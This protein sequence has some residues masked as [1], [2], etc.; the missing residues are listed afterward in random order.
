MKRYFIL[1]L[2]LFIVGIGV[3]RAEESNFDFAWKNDNVSIKSIDGFIKVN[4]G[5]LAG[6]YVNAQDSY[7]VKFDEKG[8]EVAHINLNGD[9]VVGLYERGSY[10]YALEED[11]WQLMIYKLNKTNLMVASK[12]TTPL[13]RNGANYVVEF[14]GNNAYITTIADDKFGGFYNVNTTDDALL[15]KVNLDSWNYEMVPLVE[16]SNII[17]YSQ[18]NSLYSKEYQLFI[19]EINR[20]RVPVD[21]QTNGSFNVVVGRNSANITS[22]GYVAVYDKD[23]NLLKEYKTAASSMYY[24][25]V[26]IIGNSILAVGPNHNTIDVFDFDAKLIETIEI[27]DQYEGN[28]VFN[29]MGL[30]KSAGGFAAAYLV[31]DLKSDGCAENCKQGIIKYDYLYNVL[32]KTDGNGEV[33][34]V[35]S[36]ESGN[37]EVTFN[38]K[39]NE[40]YV[41]GSV[42][43][44]DKDGKV[45]TLEKNTFTMP[46]DDVVIEA[47]FEL[48]NPETYVGYGIF[49]VLIIAILSFIAIIINV[50]KARELL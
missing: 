5:Y 35:N 23:N 38:I 36:K 41:L 34:A 48:K 1:F 12:M 30:V 37:S 11:Y 27:K 15:V 4:G 43:V 7:V 49:G 50:K 44:T 13:E 45:I 6:G 47:K 2:I 31:C 24:T 46:Y 21:V 10:Y 22:G 20:H 3:V 19:K 26:L 32:V 17:D 40:G 29:G 16:K 25:D 42:K 18:F 8:N 14:K 9:T 33:I 28:K 39:P